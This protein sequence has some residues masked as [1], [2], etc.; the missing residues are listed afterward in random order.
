M[1]YAPH[2]FVPVGLPEAEQQVIYHLRDNLSS[3]GRFV[4]SLRSAVALFDVTPRISQQ[5]NDDAAKTLVQEW[6]FI[7]ARDGAMMIYHF[8]KVWQVIPALVKQ[9]PL[10]DRH[11][12]PAEL[13][14]VGRAFETSF[15][16]WAAVR[17][18]VAHMGDFSKDAGNVAA[19]ATDDPINVPG[20][21][22]QAAG[23]YVSNSIFNQTY[24]ATVDGKVVTYEVTSE[25]VSRLEAIR[26]M[27]WN[28]FDTVAETI[29][30]E[31]RAADPKKRPQP[32][33]G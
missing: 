14:A 7:A 6:S 12:N 8:G 26:D 10:V 17:K 1:R 4:E 18:G 23:L 5:Q 32:D 28:I 33:K 21:S 11:V 25:T 3:L 20:M 19:H 29:R 24:T 16:T 22:G 9:S 27:V 31:A 2:L 15:P 30:A 13:K